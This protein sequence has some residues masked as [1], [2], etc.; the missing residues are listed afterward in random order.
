MVPK[1]PVDVLNSWND[2]AMANE[3][4][5]TTSLGVLTRSQKRKHMERTQGSVGADDGGA[6]LQ[7]G[8]SPVTRVITRV[9]R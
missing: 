7:E 6:D 5:G 2:F 8:N 3:T 4:S 1:L 9:I